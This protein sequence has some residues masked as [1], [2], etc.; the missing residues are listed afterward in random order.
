[1]ASLPLLVIDSTCPTFLWELYG[2]GVELNSWVFSSEL[3]SPGLMVWGIAGSF[4]LFTRKWIVNSSEI[5]AEILLS[6]LEEKNFR[7]CPALRALVK[8]NRKHC[9]LFVRC[10]P[11]KVVL[12]LRLTRC[13]RDQRRPSVWRACRQ[14]VNIG[15]ESALAVS[16]KT[17]LDHK[18][19]M[20]LTV[21]V[22][23]SHLR[24][25]SWSPSVPIWR[26]SWQR[27]RRHYVKSA[28]SPSFFSAD[29]RWL[30]F[31]LLLLFS[32]L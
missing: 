28:S 12:S 26:R 5:K 16:P 18:N 24:N 29:L 8:W 9:V 20:D 2:T 31:Y 13:T 6:W 25:K 30:L 7:L 32:T 10:I 23:C 22:Q 21:P 19:C 4:G 11:C 17:L 1:M 3:H 15:S 14:T 27:L